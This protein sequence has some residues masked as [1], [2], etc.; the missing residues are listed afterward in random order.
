MAK[1]S[2]EF[3][4]AGNKKDR[5]A[6]VSIP[7]LKSLVICEKAIH[8]SMT[9]NHSLINVLLAL[10]SPQFPV[11]VPLQIY[12]CLTEVRGTVELDIRLVKKAEDD[13]LAKFSAMITG[14]DPLAY[15][16]T[17]S[18]TQVITFPSPGRYE[19]Q[20]WCKD[21]FLKSQELI[22]HH[23]KQQE[24]DLGGKVM[25]EGSDDD[26][27]FKFDDTPEDFE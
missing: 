7:N 14:D 20:I 10:S 4:E 6:N 13:I 27:E 16:G 22:I 12:L 5:K 17:A 18:P 15:I 21:E 24:Y 2:W 19:F 3:M 9:C 1:R 23:I 25:N 8:D 11:T 26:S